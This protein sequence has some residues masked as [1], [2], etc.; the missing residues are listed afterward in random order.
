MARRTIA[1][2][3]LLLAAPAAAQLHG[4]LLGAPA[5]DRWNYPFNATPGTRFVLS[6]F[7]AIDEPG[8]DDYDGQVVLGFD[9]SGL[10][11]TGRG[12]DRYHVHRAVVRLY[13]ENHERFRYDPT[14]DSWRTFLDPQD[15]DFAPDADPGRPLE[16]WGSGYRG[17]AAPGVPWSIETWSE[18]SPFGSDPVVEPAQG[19]R[20]IFAATFAPGGQAVDVSNRLKDRFDP[21][22]FA[23]GQVSGVAPGELVPQDSEIAF[24]VDLC[25]PGLKRFI[26]EGLDHGIV[27]FSVA[28]LQPAVEPPGVSMFPSYY[29]REHPIGQILGLEAK[30][31]IEVRVGSVA[32]LTG[33]SR[34]VPDGVVDVS[35]FFYF[36]DL[37]AARDPLADL[38]A[39]AN[40]HDPAYGEPDCEVGVADF[41]FFLDAFAAG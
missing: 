4:G 22:P 39:T 30:L 24:E 18:T 23:I 1:A 21:T 36:L 40:P 28:S 35:D 15:P 6:T 41:F 11:P 8:F 17:E 16:L 25:A 20:H 29:A 26:A 7:G 34:G 10:V 2:A 37:F 32:D 38:T 31:E 19:S 27:R 12:L 33:P 13:V 9:T 3:A 5:E 14:F